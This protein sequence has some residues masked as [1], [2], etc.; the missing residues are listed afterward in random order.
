M[1]SVSVNLEWDLQCNEIMVAEIVN[2]AT[3]RRL[4]TMGEFGQLARPYLAAGYQREVCEA[5]RRLFGH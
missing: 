4:K 3:H 2:A 5:H 1:N